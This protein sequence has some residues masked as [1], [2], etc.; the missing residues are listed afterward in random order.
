MQKKNIVLMLCACCFNAYAQQPDV[1]KSKPDSS[2]IVVLEQEVTVQATRAQEK[3]PAT[4]T[5]LNK[6]DIEDKILNGGIT[7]VLD[8]TPSLVSTTDAGTG[9]GYSS[10]RIRGTD[11]TRI[12]ITINGIPL[13][14]MESQGAWFVNLPDFASRVE[15]VQVQRGVGT[16]ANGAASFGGSVNFQTEGISMKPFIEAG[17]SFGSFTTFRHYLK[18]GTGLMNQRFSAEGAFSMMT[19]KGYIERSA[20]Q[21]YSAYFTGNYLMEK[22]LLK[23]NV[24]HGYEK[25]GQAWDGVPYDSLKTNRRYNGLGA[26]YDADGIL[27]YYD[28]QTDNYTQTHYQLFF[29]HQFNEQWNLNLAGH[30]T[31]GKG[32]Y[33]QYRY[34]EKFSKYGLDPF[35]MG[36]KTVSKTDLIRR[37]YLDNYF[38]GMLFS[39]TYQNQKNIELIFGGAVNYY[40][41]RHYGDIIWMQYAGNI[42]KDYRWYNGTGNKLNANAYTKLNWRASQNTRL[43]FDVQYRFINYQIKGIDDNLE[44][45]TQGY[46]WH[47]LNPKVG[48][49]QNINAQN[50]LYFSFGM[51]NREPARTDLIDAPADKKP[52]YETL[53]DFELGHVFKT[54]KYSLKTNGY[55][56]YYHNQLVLTGEINDV[57]DAIMRNVKQSY[58]LGVEIQ[59]DYKPLK[60][61]KWSING[62]FSLNKVLKLTAYVDDWDSWEQQSEYLGNT[63]ISFSPAVVLNNRLT[64]TPVE[65]F[66]I[67]LS[68]QF[69]SRQYIDNT[70]NKARS[71]NPY[72]VTHLN[73]AYTFVTKAIPEIRLFCGVR[74][75]F[76]AK[77]ETNAWVYR[78]YEAGTEC[79]MNGYFPQATIHVM[80]GIE[81]R[82]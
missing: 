60:W 53:Y 59:S 61:L 17:E 5:D 73:L 77:Y 57:G 41:G 25:T 50:S 36:E 79:E 47:F 66:E 24:L 14:D 78:Y 81:I 18:A 51:A 48:I 20:S 40:Q 82:F 39:S 27:K 13:N 6:S 23:F 43:Y 70:S 22:S 63:N 31:R 76:N 30:L 46:N 9:V 80:G 65:R 44:D 19:S 21:M 42:P 34:Q 3:T 71:L 16:S 2:K 67:T 56:M 54:E 45:V 26:Y 35:V 38:Y 49:Y 12:N 15:N 7:E 37:K 33:E 52:V 68:T 32:Y 64:F 62:A 4:F 75:L 10:F 8:G 11:G 72:S 29:L 58:R 74:N 28:N 55:A 69:V 1:S